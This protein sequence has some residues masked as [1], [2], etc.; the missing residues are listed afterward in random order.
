MRLTFPQGPSPVLPCSNHDTKDAVTVSD[1]TLAVRSPRWIGAGI[2][3]ATVPVHLA[4]EQPASIALAAVTLA[5][6]AGAYIGFGARA[7]SARA[8]W[9]ELA[10][11]ILFALSALA[12]LLWHWSALPVGLALHAVWDLLHHDRR[13]GAPVPRWY[14]PL[15]VVFDLAA[16]AFLAALYAL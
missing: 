14:I 1:R 6:I 12:G 16:A 11:A 9:L 7:D 5:L 4:L 10:V 15:C 2:F 13:I 8:L 3:A